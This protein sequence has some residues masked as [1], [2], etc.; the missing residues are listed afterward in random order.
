[1]QARRGDGLTGQG[2][3]ALLQ[4]LDAGGQSKR[5]GLAAAGGTEQAEQFSGLGV[6]GDVIKHV[7][8]AEGMA[9]AFQFENVVAHARSITLL[10]ITDSAMRSCSVA[11]EP[12]RDLAMAI[13]SMITG[14]MPTA[15]MAKDGAAAS[16]SRSSEAN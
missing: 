8:I 13:D 6:D 3:A 5:G 15:T 16:A 11:S 7:G 10:S 1:M 12:G 4:F 14:T 9:H 2:D